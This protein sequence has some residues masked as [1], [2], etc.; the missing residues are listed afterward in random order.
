MKTIE[1]TLKKAAELPDDLQ[2]EVA[3]F[4]EFLAERRMRSGL[5]ARDRAALATQLAAMAQD[6]EVQAELREIEREFATAETDGL[7]NG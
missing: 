1:E 4:V 6:S 7:E 5:G 3:D 2:E